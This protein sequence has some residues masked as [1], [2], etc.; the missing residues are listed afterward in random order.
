M[1]L[2][3]LALARVPANTVDKDK[4]I[5]CGIGAGVAAA[6][7]NTSS[8][9]G[10]VPM[11]LTRAVTD[12]SAVW[13]NSYQASQLDTD[14]ATDLVFNAALEVGGVIYR[15]LFGGKVSA[16]VAPG[17]TITSDP[18]PLDLPA[19]TVVYVRTFVVSGTWY[20]R[21]TAQVAGSGGVGGAGVDLTAPG[22]ATIADSTSYAA[23]PGP[24]QLMGRTGSSDRR[25]IIQAGDSIGYG[26][27]DGF[28]PSQGYNTADAKLGRGGWIGRVATAAGLGVINVGTPGDRLELFVTLANRM[29]RMAHVR[30]GTHA[31]VNYSRND[32]SVG[33]TLAQVQASAL[34]AA[35]L[36]TARGLKVIWPT[37]TVLT[38]STDGWRTTAGQTLPASDAVRLTWNAWLRDGAPLTAGAPAATG[39]AGATRAPVYGPDGTLATP[40]SADAQ[41][42]PFSSIVD[43]AAAAESGG[44][45]RT[46][47][48]LRNAGDAVTTAANANVTATASFVAADRGR[49]VTIA[50]A[51]T[52]GALYVGI[53]KQVTNST[54]VVVSPTVPT[55]VT[56]AQLYVG[57]FPTLDGTHPGPTVH[58]DMALAVPP[59]CGALVA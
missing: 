13:N 58:D 35:A 8:L 4:L 18:L 41:A 49:Q 29:R 57:D 32:V 51:G 3:I 21:T 52:A 48:N 40:G 33:K 12:L 44:K 9:T 55:A 20:T 23:V 42:H 5:P 2:N 38:T 22:S 28:T 10:R 1:T 36:F 53:I 45:W 43:P 15:C 34:T 24:T 16:T 50:G 6:T 39:T 26:Q 11:L 47:T 25:A 30:H 56:A 27:G 7:A 17:G 19:G 37:L 59:T 54:T 14:G 46:P 31:I